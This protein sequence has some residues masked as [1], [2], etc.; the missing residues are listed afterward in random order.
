M[1]D[2]APTSTSVTAEVGNGQ[3]LKVWQD[4]TRLRRI[5]GVIAKF[6]LGQGAVQAVNAI[7]AL[8]LVHML[9]TEAYAQ[10]GLAFGFQT[11]ASTLMDLG[12][13]STII[14]L[15]GDRFDDQ[16]LVGR[17]VLAARR[18]RNRAFLFLAPLTAT[19]FFA[20]GHKQHWRLTVQL[21]LALS[22][23][24]SLYSSG[25]VACYS[26]P[27]VLYRRLKEYYAPQTVLG[28]LRL[29]AYEILHILGA[30]NAWTAAALSALNVTFVSRILARRSK[31]LIVVSEDETRSTEREIISYILPAMPAVIFAAFQSQ[32]TLFLVSIFGHTASIAQ[33]A[34]LG[35]IAQLF[36][37]LQVFY[38]VIVE[39]H[40]A[41]LRRDRLPKVYLGLIFLAIVGFVPLVAFAFSY[42]QAILWLLGSKY[43]DLRDMVG[44][45][46]LATCLNQLAA[47]M[48]IMNRARKWVFWSGTALEIVLLLG[49]QIVFIATVGVR[50]AREAVELS[51]ASSVCY[52]IAHGYTGI[53]G[54]LTGARLEHLKP[55][56]SRL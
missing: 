54:F 31:L 35:R 4:V 34:A 11:T 24:L 26:A 45:L 46:V 15:V 14:P 20:I 16:L 3:S 9:S 18:L 48:Y 23:L 13:A 17:Y 41:R 21:L 39:P 37:I 2:S 5:A 44:W 36:M 12:F 40:V 51:L 30:L 55:D 7:V 33:V 10:F 49:V 25:N 27:F 6:F 28:I 47:L 56:S 22:V 42:P 53:Y 29:V 50:T 32:I 38:M 43:S 19:V 1:Q 8:F 52:L